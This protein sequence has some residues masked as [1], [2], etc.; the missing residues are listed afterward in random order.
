MLRLPKRL[1]VATAALTLGLGALGITQVGL[2]SG[3]AALSAAPAEKVTICHAAGLAGTTHYNTLTISGNAVYGPAGHFYENGT[4]QAGHE[5][6]YLG[7][8]GTPD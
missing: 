8:C 1:A 2:F 3:S 4:P 6:D 7:P 5:Q